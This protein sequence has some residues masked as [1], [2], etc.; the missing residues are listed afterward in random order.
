MFGWF[1][2]LGYWFR[3][4]VSSTFGKSA[5]KSLSKA[6][7]ELLKGEFGKLVFKVVAELAVSNLSTGEKRQA[8][9]D[10]IKADTVARGLYI[11]SSLINLAIEMAVMGRKDHYSAE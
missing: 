6:V 2:K 7:K 5:A 9:F 8:A 1:K 4:Y 11:K 10:R 3:V